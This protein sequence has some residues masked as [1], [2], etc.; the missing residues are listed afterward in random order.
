MCF[1]INSNDDPPNQC[2][3]QLNGLP[4]EI[5]WKILGYLSIKD[6]MKIR[7]VDKKWRQWSFMDVRQL[8]VGKIE[9]DVFN[10]IGGLSGLEINST[11][12][13][14]NQ[15]KALKFLLKTCGQSVRNLFIGPVFELIDVN[16]IQVIL[17][18]PTY[19]PNL[20]GLH[21]DPCPSIPED[22]YFSLYLHFGA[23]LET[24]IFF[25]AFRRSDCQFV[26][27]H[28][29]PERLRVLTV[30]VESQEH[31]D[32]VAKKF[33]LLTKFS[34][35]PEWI[36]PEMDFSSLAKMQQLQEFSFNFTLSDHNFRSLMNALA[37]LNL[38]KLILRES[39][40]QISP[41]AF[42]L[43]QKVKSLKSLD[44]IVNGSEHL[45]VILEPLKQLEYLNL[46]LESI[47]TNKQYM[48]RTFLAISKL[49]KLKEL[50]LRLKTRIRLNFSSFC[51]MPSLT[52]FHL[53]VKCCR[54]EKFETSHP[55]LAFPNI[56]PNLIELNFDWQV[57]YQFL[58]TFITK[59]AALK[60]L[61]IRG[62]KHE[63]SL[64]GYCRLKE[65]SKKHLDDY[66]FFKPRKIFDQVVPW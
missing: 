17:S 57:P 10:F 60:R 4:I 52:L 22:V 6:R 9:T 33:P 39:C 51:P 44:I 28:L 34:A 61:T 50:K 53:K 48:D 56:F 5:I 36:F 65:I 29:N 19:C 15:C 42:Q 58:L 66:P 41:S 26:V 43:F 13:C 12:G 32:E 16:W 18:I 46:R 25:N 27:Q 62:Y 8:I 37:S 3:T 23:R 40:E 64:E 49:D 2:P 11:T 47:E 31:M 35:W 24:A 55:V 20:V 30:S 1:Q 45:E 14:N 7:R 63:S 54:E 21:I 59:L 38:Q